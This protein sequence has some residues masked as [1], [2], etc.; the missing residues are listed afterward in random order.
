[1][2]S[3]T[4]GMAVCVVGLGHL[5][6]A[7][8]ARLAATGFQTY[9][10]DIAAAA[11]DRSAAAGVRVR[12]RL[13]DAVA[14]ADAVIT[15]LPDG[16]AVTEAWLGQ[17][18]LVE[19][20]RPG[21]YLIELSTIGPDTMRAVAGPAAA[22][23]LK[24]V[25]APVSGGPMD[26]AKG[27]LVVIAG[28]DEPD[29]AAVQPVLRA[30]AGAVHL[31]GPLGTAKAVK[32]VNNL[33]TNATVLVSAEAFQIG[34]AAGLAPRR[35]FDL[36]SQMGGGR[37][38][39]FQKRFP[40]VLERDFDARFSIRLAEKDFRLGLELA[41]RVGVP[42]PA[43]SAIRSIYAVAVAEGLADDDIVGLVRLYERWTRPPGAVE[44]PAAASP[45]PVE[46]AVTG[47]GRQR[48]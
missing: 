38:H 16:A 40:W 27:Q 19:S 43:A 10:F 30:V 48:R 34:V 25:D 37:S 24:P 11:R 4:P 12:D 44:A 41:D 46:S 28:G 5:G 13:P 47:D 6:G 2:D 22:A 9:G 23:G 1:M 33:I 7:V 39:H 18:G 26:A 20:A 31:S 42:P 14:G 17:G 45:D 3:R 35:L 32:L 36:L 21:T 15:S 29:I 8:A